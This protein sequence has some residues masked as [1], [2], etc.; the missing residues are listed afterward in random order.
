MTNWDWAEIENELNGLLSSLQRGERRA[1]GNDS[2]R[3]ALQTD[4][5]S[6]LAHIADALL[7]ER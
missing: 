2:V 6:L 1:S 7:Q 5:Q 3:Q 4:E